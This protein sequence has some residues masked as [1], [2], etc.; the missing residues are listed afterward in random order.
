MAAPQFA[1]SIFYQNSNKLISKIAAKA[2]KM[3][4]TIVAAA[5]KFCLSLQPQLWSQNQDF[6]WFSDVNTT[7]ILEAEV[8]GS[9]ISQQLHW[10]HS[11]FV[12]Y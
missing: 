7:K 8:S 1:L 12:P 4:T 2:L 11:D 3:S 10:G 5:S 6:L 9:F